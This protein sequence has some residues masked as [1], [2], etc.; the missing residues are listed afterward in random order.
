MR[1]KAVIIA[2]FYSYSFN[3]RLGYFEKVLNEMGYDSI[4][5][6]ADFDHRSKSYF[7]NQKDNVQLVHV[8]SYMKNISLDRMFSHIEFAKRAFRVAIKIK[9]DLLYVGSPPNSNVKVFSKFKDRC[10]KTKVLVSV[11]D[12][13]PET[14]PVKSIIKTVLKPIFSTWAGWRNRNLRKYD[15]IIFECDLF[16]DYLTKYFKGV[17]AKTIYM[18][19]KDCLDYEHGGWHR[20]LEIEQEIGFAYIGSVNNIIDIDMI[21]D[22]LVCINQTRKAKIVL[23]GNGEKVKELLLKCA[24][25]NIKVENYGSVFEDLEKERILQECHFGL[26]IMRNTVFVGATMKSLEYLYFGLPLVNTIGGDTNH[27]VE[28]CGCGINLTKQNIKHVSKCIVELSTENYEQMNKNAR[29]VFQ[30]YFS[31]QSVYSS[32][33]L[34]LEEI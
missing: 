15:G 13:W 34:F 24:Q 19:K 29:T 3:T 14:F 32:I 2:C 28:Q 31:E 7:I 21:V 17:P 30:T 12:M 26:N 18:A 8:R 5:L 22:L 4:I 9:P 33:K 20:N 6:A 25:N 16:K 10:P 23:L 11:S 1:K 27:I